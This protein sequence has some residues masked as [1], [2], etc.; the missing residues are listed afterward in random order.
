MSGDFEGELSIEPVVGVRVFRVDDMG[1][2]RGVTHQDIW[3]PGENTAACHAPGPRMPSRPMGPVSLQNQP[4]YLTFDDPFHTAKSQRRAA[5]KADVR[6]KEW[7]EECRR[8]RDEWKGHGLDK[9]EHGFWAYY[10]PQG[11]FASADTVYA[12]VEGFGECVIGT[13]G[14]RASKARIV[15][16]SLPPT[17]NEMYG[18]QLSLVQ[19]NYPHVPTYPSLTRMLAEHPLSRNPEPDGEDFWTEPTQSDDPTA[20]MMQLIQAFGN[21]GPPQMHYYQSRHAAGGFIS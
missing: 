19:R 3:R 10:T 18:Y 21:I 5:R 20:S 1:R 14:F 17:T 15:A 11:R 12:V 9:C 7:E 13:K 16:L 4:W 8:I 6:M 2:L